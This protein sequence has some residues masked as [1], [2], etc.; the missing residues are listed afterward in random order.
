MHYHIVLTERC[1]SNCRYCYEKSMQE[2]DNSLSKKWEFDY[3]VPSESQVEAEKISEF[4]EAGDSLIFYGGEPLVNFQ[5]M[6]EIIDFIESPES[7]KAGQINFQ[8]QTN[9]KL[10]DSIPSEYINKISKML[11]SIDGRRER[12]DFNRGGGT[13]DKVIE[14]IKKIRKHGFKGE[15]VAR[16]TLS[17]DIENGWDIYEQVMHLIE[18]ID[19]GIFDS[20]HWQIDA[21]FY[22]FDYNNEKFSEFV[23]KYN[24]STEKLVEFWVENIRKGKVYKLYPFLGI[25]ESLY[26]N[27]PSKLRCGSGYANYTINTNGQISPCPI[28]N[29]VKSFY[30][31]S[32]DSKIQGGSLKEFHIHGEC[33]DCEYLWICGGRCL[34]ENYSKLW[35]EEGRELICK[36]IIHLIESIKKRITDIKECINGGIV[37]ESDFIYEKYFGPEIIP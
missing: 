7:G 29:D 3:N 18:L 36:T 33:K 6:K 35:P 34:Y 26:Y 28:M 12:T 30:C 27:K 15:I 16:M 2:F 14:N 21:G 1:N 24:K 31:G 22:E 9:G 17:F 25:F 5:K 8:M 19:K 37:N 11:V 13:Y 4:L 20:V 32:L 10:L 23:E